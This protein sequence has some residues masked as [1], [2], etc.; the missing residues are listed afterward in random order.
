MLRRSSYIRAYANPANSFEAGEASRI[1]DQFDTQAA[2][3]DGVVRWISNAQVP[4]AD[5][6][7]FWRYLGK[8]FDFDASTAA[9]DREQAEFLAEYRRQASL[10]PIT[11]ERQAELLAA[12]GPGARVTNV[13]T[14]QTDQLPGRP[15]AFLQG[16]SA[17][18]DGPAPPAPF[19]TAC[20]RGTPRP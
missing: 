6:L 5:I 19:G 9:R 20:A 8:A 2:V 18:T 12:F 3:V 13:I 15:S 16:A 17:E 11:G 10:R 4:P 1:A 14:G 7:E